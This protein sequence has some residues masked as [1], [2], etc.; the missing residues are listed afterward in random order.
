MQAQAHLVLRFPLASI[1]RDEAGSAAWLKELFVT[2]DRLLDSFAKSGRFEE[3]KKGNIYETKTN[4]TG[5]V[6]PAWR[7]SLAWSSRG[8]RTAGA[9]PT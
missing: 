6:S 2:K 1:P 8:G 5:F 3:E 4:P 7:S 9:R